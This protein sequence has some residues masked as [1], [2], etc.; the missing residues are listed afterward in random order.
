MSQPRFL[1]LLQQKSGIHMVPSWKCGFSMSNYS[2]LLHLVTCRVVSM[3]QN[4][5]KLQFFRLLTALKSSRVVIS[6]NLIIVKKFPPI[7]IW[8]SH[9]KLVLL[10]SSNISKVTCN[11]HH[12]YGNYTNLFLA[13]IGF[14]LPTKSW[15]LTKRVGVKTFLNHSFDISLHIDVFLY[16]GNVFLFTNLSSINGYTCYVLIWRSIQ[17]ILI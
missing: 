7:K 4:V 6:W 2:W 9:T 16:S 12:H 17:S 14:R 8:S 15:I 3:V 10:K 5:Q 11:L 13:A 1:H